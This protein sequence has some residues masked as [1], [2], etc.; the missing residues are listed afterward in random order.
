MRK[1]LFVGLA[2]LP[3]ACGLFEREVVVTATPPP[4]TAVPP[5]TAA[6]TEAP[7]ALPKNTPEP[8]L[9][10]EPTWEPASIGDIEAALGKAG[11][12][13]FP[14]TTEDGTSGFDWINDNSYE[15]VTTWEDGTVELSVLHGS[16]ASA[17]ADRL[18]GHLAVM[19]TVL[20]HGFMAK[21]REQHAAYNRSV[22][23]SVTGEPDEIFAYGDEWQTV[24]GEYNASEIDIGGYGVRF[25]LWWWQSTCPAQ[26]DYCYYGDFPGLEFTGD[27]SFVFHTILIW[28]PVEGVESGGNA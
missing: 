28:L 23:S 9:T 6:P 22:S 24:W 11:Y 10:P 26:Y 5:P 19:D 12:R 20:P 18:E 15:Q 25:S 2:L 4:A 1:Y 16:S 8:T 27:S 17:R 3:I 14:F 21:L 13:R 7:T